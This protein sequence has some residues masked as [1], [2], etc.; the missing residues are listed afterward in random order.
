MHSGR[1]W[2][3]YVPNEI[4]GRPFG[5]YAATRLSETDWRGGDRPV[6]LTISFTATGKGLFWENRETLIEDISALA[7]N[8]SID[9][10]GTDR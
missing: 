9:Y 7:G 10:G 4:D 2:G 8:V 3:V 6:Y 1:V 5:V